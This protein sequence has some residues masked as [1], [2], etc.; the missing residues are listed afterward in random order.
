MRKAS[1]PGSLQGGSEAMAEA[2]RVMKRMEDLGGRGIWV[3][4]S[5]RHE[6]PL[7]SPEIGKIGWFLLVF[8]AWNQCVFAAS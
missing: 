7:N 1:S 6:D 5:V 3:L 2:K 4:V 8:V